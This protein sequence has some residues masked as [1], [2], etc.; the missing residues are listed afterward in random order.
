M[1][2]FIAPYK[3]DFRSIEQIVFEFEKKQL[4]CWIDLRWNETFD[5]FAMLFK[6]GQS[7]FISSFPCTSS[8]F[9]LEIVS[10]LMCFGH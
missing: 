4:F 8:S 7:F 9:Q 2:M 5:A 10:F 1:A 3:G 6:W